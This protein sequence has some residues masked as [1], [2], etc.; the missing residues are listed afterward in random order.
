[1]AILP[2]T[3]YSHVA[4]SMPEVCS[5][6]CS[7]GTDG[8]AGGGQPAHTEA[9]GAAAIVDGLHDQVSMW[10]AFAASLQ[11]H[12]GPPTLLSH[13]VGPCAACAT[14]PTRLSQCTDGARHT[15]RQA[16]ALLSKQCEE[17]CPF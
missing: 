5:H 16:Q 10:V 14:H 2:A 7:G 17:H 13:G 11:T 6:V 3:W 15:H 12:C 9:H 8:P 1:M 4:A